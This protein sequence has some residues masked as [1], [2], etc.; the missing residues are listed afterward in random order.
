MT[1]VNKDTLIEADISSQQKR[2]KELNAVFFSK[3]IHS[4]KLVFD[5]TNNGEEMDYTTLTDKKVIFVF[6]VGEIPM[7]VLDLN[8]ETINEKEYLT[9]ELPPEWSGYVGKISVSPILQDAH[10]QVDVGQFVFKMAKSLGDD[11]LPKLEEVLYGQFGKEFVALKDYLETELFTF[12][13]RLIEKEGDVQAIKQDIE[14]LLAVTTA[15]E[16]MDFSSFATREMLDTVFAQLVANAP[17]ELNNFKAVADFILDLEQNML[18]KEEVPPLPDFN[19]Y[20]KAPTGKGWTSGMATLN[21][22]GT[23]FLGSKNT[24][25]ESEKEP[26]YNATRNYVTSQTERAYIY[27]NNKTGTDLYRTDEVVLVIPRINSAG[28]IARTYSGGYFPRCLFLKLPEATKEFSGLLTYKNQEIAG[29]KT[30]MEIPEITATLEETN[31]T[32][33]HQLVPKFYVDNRLNDLTTTI[34]QLQT[35]IEE[36]E[37]GT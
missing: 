34:A 24:G 30:F 8:V 37:S 7:T 15:L 1:N 26:V 4:P 2:V 31:L 36:L 27:C 32:K 6:Q 12:S 22:S 16:N 25:S 23:T 33:S 19:E 28:D 10:G 29:I 5:L 14:Q 3:D 9:V 11:T 20:Q 35:R 13:A 18:R 17:E 21:N